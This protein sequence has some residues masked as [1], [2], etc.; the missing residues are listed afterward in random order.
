MLVRPQRWR[1]LAVASC[2][3]QVE[4]QFVGTG[5]SGQTGEPTASQLHGR[6]AGARDALS[7]DARRTCWF[8]P[9]CSSFFQSLFLTACIV[10]KTYTTKQ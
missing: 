8:V 9:S 10:A 1:R 3:D 2:C 7:H 4:V 5:R 6:V